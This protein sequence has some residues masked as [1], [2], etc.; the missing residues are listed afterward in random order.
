ML[1]MTEPV[2]EFIIPGF[3]EY[4]EKSLKSISQGDIDLGSEEEKKIAEEQKT[5]ASGKYKKLIKKVQ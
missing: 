1:F 4:L 3:G 5:E 2:D